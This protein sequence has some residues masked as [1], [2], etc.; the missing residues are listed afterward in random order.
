MN[1]ECVLCLVYLIMRLKGEKK[2]PSK[3]RRNVLTLLCAGVGT[4]NDIGFQF[5]GLYIKVRGDCTGYPFLIFLY[6]W[7]SFLPDVFFIFFFFF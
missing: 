3:S 5:R 4:K 6:F 1:D 2:K 7:L